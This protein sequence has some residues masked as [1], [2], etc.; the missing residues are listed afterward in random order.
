MYTQFST[1][2]FKLW[3]PKTSQQYTLRASIDAQ[4]IKTTHTIDFD[5]LLN[6]A[7]HGHF[8]NKDNNVEY[9]HNTFTWCV[10]TNESIHLAMIVNE[11]LNIS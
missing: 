11:Y 1:S 3:N 10:M 6:I 9:L 5:I 2:N 4:Q 7:D 8:L